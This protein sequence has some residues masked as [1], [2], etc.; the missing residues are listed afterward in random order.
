VKAQA[1]LNELETKLRQTENSVCLRYKI[2]A[3]VFLFLAEEREGEDL[4]DASEGR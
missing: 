3:K 4:E 2:R 1:R